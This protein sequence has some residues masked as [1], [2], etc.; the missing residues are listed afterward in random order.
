MEAKKQLKK[1]LSND[2]LSHAYLF[3]GSENTEKEAVASWFLKKVGARGAQKDADRVWRFDVY[4]LAPDRS[5]KKPVIKIESIRA[6]KRF[7]G[8]SPV[9]GDFKGAL[10]K[11]ADYMNKQAANAFLK[12]LEEPQPG[13]LIVLCAENPRRLPDTIVSRCV[14]IDFSPSEAQ[15]KKRE[16]KSQKNVL[17]TNLNENFQFAESLSKQETEEIQRFLKSLML[18]LKA[19][20]RE[21]DI[22]KRKKSAKLIKRAKQTKNDIELTNAKNR[23]ALER[24]MLEI[25]RY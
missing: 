20:L 24:L 19:S 8:L 1:T 3:C 11:E 22:E 4:K 10:V 9:Y 21:G 25:V 18:K 12:V 2:K 5:K 13:R 14:R 17:D 6:L 16:E 23:L 7:L 15:K